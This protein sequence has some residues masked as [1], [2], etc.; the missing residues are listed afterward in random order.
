METTTKLSRG[1]PIDFLMMAVTATVWASAFIAIKIAVV[2]A[3]PMWVATWRVVIGFAVLLP[4]AL[5]R[6]FLWP[7]NRTIWLLIFVTAAFNV[8]F[9]FLLISWAET[10]IDAG[11][12]SLLM[13]VG[14]FFALIATHLTTDDEKINWRKSLGCLLGFAGV[15]TV[16]GADALGGLGSA[17]VLAQLAVVGAAFCYTISGILIRKIDLPPV[18]LVT[19]IFM[20]GTIMLA[21]LAFATVG[22]PPTNLSSGAFWALIYLGVMPTALAQLLRVT[23]VKRVG[24]ALFALALNI[25]PVIGVVMGALILG[26]VIGPATLIALVLVL[27]GL[28]V[29]RSEPKAI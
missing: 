12:T 6:G 21:P 29:A 2:D 14:P 20:A 9:P 23:I 10:T 16:V 17:G 11:L 7:A 15:L 22:P 24:Y 8:V 25:I 19:L 1:E 28:A 3:G 5:W 4:Y 27:A 26:E 18:R 13:G